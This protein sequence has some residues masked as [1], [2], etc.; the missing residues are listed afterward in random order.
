MVKMELELTP[1]QDADLAEIVKHHPD[2]YP[3][4][5]DALKALGLNSY[6]ELKE[7]T[8]PE[9]KKPSMIVDTIHTVDNL[10]MIPCAAAELFAQGKALLVGNQLRFARDSDTGKAWTIFEANCKAAGLE[11]YKAF[12]SIIEVAAKRVDKHVEISLPGADV[13]MNVEEDK[14]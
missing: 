13:V 4:K 7:K 5:A 8:D 3:T 2:K 10:G 11:P 12:N 14:P 9:R 6:R 1:A